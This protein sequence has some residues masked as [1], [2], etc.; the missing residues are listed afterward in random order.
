MLSNLSSGSEKQLLTYA[1]LFFRIHRKSQV[2]SQQRPRE[3]NANESKHYRYYSV[4]LL[5]FFLLHSVSG[6]I[7]CPN[8]LH[9][10]QP[11]AENCKRNVS[12]KDAKLKHN[13]DFS[14]TSKAHKWSKNAR[15]IAVFGNFHWHTTK[16]V[17]DS[18]RQGTGKCS[19]RCRASGVYCG[20]QLQTVPPQ[21]TPRSHSPRTNT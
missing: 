15:K 6:K 5:S 13:L 14:S 21:L 8:S 10:R 18:D 19:A 1:K 16:T 3:S 7:L 20:A 9:L 4:N 2:Q 11:S 12:K 17:N